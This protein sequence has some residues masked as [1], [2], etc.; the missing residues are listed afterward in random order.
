[1]EI[2]SLNIYGSTR[3]YNLYLANHKLQLLV[4]NTSGSVIFACELVEQFKKVSRCAN[5]RRRGEYVCVENGEGVAIKNVRED[6]QI[7]TFAIYPF[8]HA[9]H[10]PLKALQAG[11]GAQLG[12]HD[13]AIA[14]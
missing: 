13:S 14:K 2:R 4:Y 5:C 9:E 10:C 3:N 11:G 8:T 7:P 6:W 12:S 1:M